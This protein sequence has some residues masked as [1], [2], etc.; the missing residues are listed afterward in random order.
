MKVKHMDLTA[1][2]MY[3]GN[4]CTICCFFG[5]D[6]VCVRDKFPDLGPCISETKYYK[7][8]LKSDIFNL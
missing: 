8:I 6:M 3:G 7:R 5:V 2:P 4:S 1:V